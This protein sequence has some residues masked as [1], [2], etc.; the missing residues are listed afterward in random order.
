MLSDVDGFLPG[1]YVDSCFYDSNIIVRAEHEN[2]V[3]FVCDT[4][5]WAV[6]FN[7]S[8]RMDVFL[9]FVYEICDAADGVSFFVY[10]VL[11]RS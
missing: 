8:V 3:V 4:D 7:V 5:I 11:R 6:I 9:R 2:K 10:A 1:V